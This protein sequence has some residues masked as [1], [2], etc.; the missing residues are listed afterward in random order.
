MKTLFLALA[1]LFA[2]PSICAQ[3]VTRKGNVITE[4]QKTANKDKK[5]VQ[6]KKTAYTYV[7]QG[8][9]YQVYQGARGGYYILYTNKKAEQKRKYVTK[10]LKEVG[11]N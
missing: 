11:I 8:K 10:Q 9:T 2:T 3:N 5:P 6:D 4:V 7:W 1:L